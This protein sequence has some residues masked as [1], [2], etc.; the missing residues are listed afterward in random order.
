MSKKILGLL[1]LS[2]ALFFACEDYKPTAKEEAKQDT[3]TEHKSKTA[4]EK[5]T[6]L[7]F[8][9]QGCCYPLPPIIIC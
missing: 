1:V 6:K 4:A 2:S 5:K 9:F 8:K 3:K 7:N